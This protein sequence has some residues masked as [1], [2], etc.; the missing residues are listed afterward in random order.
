MLQTIPHDRIQARRSPGRH[1][2]LAAGPRGPD[3]EAPR[4]GPLRQP[5]GQAP[6]IAAPRSSP[7]ALLRGWPDRPDGR[8]YQ[9]AWGRGNRRSSRSWMTS[10]AW[11]SNPRQRKTMQS[12]HIPRRKKAVEQAGAGRL[13]AALAAAWPRPSSGRWR[14]RREAS[15]YRPL[16][17][18]RPRTP[19]GLPHDAP[20]LR[21]VLP[22]AQPFPRPGF[23]SAAPVSAIAAV[24]TRTVRTMLV[25]AA[26]S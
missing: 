19:H 14:W 10:R 9:C 17:R 25:R 6:A 12:S 2:D 20:A 5:A 15:A 3:P 4:L 22:Q 16:R 1:V 21:A 26:A 24:Q 11:W 18:L 8:E 7:S 13:R 23:S